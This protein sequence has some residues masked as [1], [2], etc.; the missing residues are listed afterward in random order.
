[1]PKGLKEGE[2][3][4][5]MF[6][7]DV[8]NLAKAHA[9]KS[10]YAPNLNRS[11]KNGLKKLKR[12]I[13]EGELVC[14][15]TDKSGRWSVDSPEN[16]KRACQVHLEDAEKTA[17]ITHTMHDE[18]EVELN[19]EGAALLRMLGLDEQE[20][21]RGER[22]RKAITAHGVSVA[23]LYGTRKDHKIVEPGHEQIGPKVRPVCG[24][25]DCATKRVSYLLCLL[26]TPLIGLSKTHCSS[27]IDMLQEIENLNQSRKLNE[28]CMIGS[29][30]ID[31]LYPSL[32]ISRCAKVVSQKLYN[33][34]LKFPGLD[35]KEI[36]LYLTFHL[37]NDEIL[38]EG[39]R[40]FCPKRR[41]NRGEGPKFTASGSKI[42]KN[43]RFLPW[44]FT[45]EAPTQQ[46]TRKMF[47]IAVRIMII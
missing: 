42:K 26:T 21:S 31:S 30:D 15:V 3:R 37:T 23:P 19:S 27:T 8:H 44:I 7:E 28:N 32:D 12:R 36:G 45:E 4:L 9:Q 18:A 20:G 13:K 41:S 2:F 40:E 35:W 1:M 24:A 14:F 33:S 16:Y 5:H 10:R 39:I 47:C 34:D 17:P 29:L 25:E 11:K 22:L 43:E 6:K 38:E 46:I